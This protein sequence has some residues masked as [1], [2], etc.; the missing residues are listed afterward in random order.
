MRKCF[1]KYSNRN[2]YKD[3]DHLWGKT[4]KAFEHIYENYLDEY[5]WFLKAD[6]DTYVIMQNLRYFLYEYPTEMP[7]YFGC[8]FKK[9]I[10]LKNVHH[11]KNGEKDEF[12]NTFRQIY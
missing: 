1:T 6:D 8:R 7:I 11:Q 4:K 3:R 12:V 5:D 9:V 2:F 10:N